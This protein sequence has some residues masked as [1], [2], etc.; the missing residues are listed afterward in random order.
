MPSLVGSEMCIRDSKNISIIKSLKIRLKQHILRKKYSNNLITQLFFPIYQILTEKFINQLHILGKLNFKII[1]YWDQDKISIFH[2]QLMHNQINTFLDIQNQICINHKF[3]NNQTE[4]EFVFKAS[5][6]QNN[7]QMKRQN[8]NKKNLHQSM[9]IKFQIQGEC[10]MIKKSQFK[11]QKRL[12]INTIITTIQKQRR[13]LICQIKQ[14]NC[15]MKL[16]IT[17]Q[18]LVKSLKKT[19]NFQKSTRLQIMKIQIQNLSQARSNLLL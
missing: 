13:F 17:N 12:N 3:I 1:K 15:I 4:K 5:F 7:K 18:Q 2:N 11:N 6:L 10:Q 16:T 8:V 19:I 9:K 14:L